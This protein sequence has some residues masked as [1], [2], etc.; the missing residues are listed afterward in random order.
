MKGVIQEM[1]YFIVI[2]LVIF[3][4]FVFFTYVRGTKGIEVKKSVEGRVLNEEIA[5]LALTLFNN[6]VP[7]AEKVHLELVIDSILEGKFRERE[8]Y[9]VYYGAGI[10]KL[11]VTDVIPPVLDLY[12]KDR[13]EVKIETPDGKYSY[14]KIQSGKVLY[15]YEIMIP[16]PEERVGMMIVKMG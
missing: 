8:L 4:L 7:H 11:N 6:K 13:L 1:F 14:G 9:K 10:G 5:G 2:V 16:V 3:M 15:T 12:A